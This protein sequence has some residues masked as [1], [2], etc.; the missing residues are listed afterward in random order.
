MRLDAN[1]RRRFQFLKS[2]DGGGQPGGTYD[3]WQDAIDALTIR[4]A[5]AA[6]PEDGVG[7]PSAVAILDWRRRR[8]YSSSEGPQ[9]PR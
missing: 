1:G 3:S 7:G 2:R 5:A 6:P 4:E 9:S 8:G